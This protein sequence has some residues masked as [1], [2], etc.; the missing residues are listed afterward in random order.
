MRKIFTFLVLLFCMTCSLRAEVVKIQGIPVSGALATSVSAHQ[1]IA[2][3][4][5][6]AFSFDDIQFWVGEG[7]NK[8]A[9]V[10]QWNAEGETNALVWGY[11]WDGNAT[12]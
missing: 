4:E 1:R 8:A 7:E 5:A 9:L 2:A 10:L 11:R 6:D 12:V 3:A